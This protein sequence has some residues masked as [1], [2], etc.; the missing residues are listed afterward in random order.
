MKDPKTKNYYIYKYTYIHIQK[1]L[2]LLTN[3][4]LIGIEQ[5][6]SNAKNT[7]FLYNGGIE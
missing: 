4:N 1:A 2:T 6:I 7:T 3:Q 5:P